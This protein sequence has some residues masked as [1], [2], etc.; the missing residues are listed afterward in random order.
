MNDF[1]VLDCINKNIFDN[2]INI[3]TKILPSGK[4]H[5]RLSVYNSYIWKEAVENFKL[6]NNK[7]AVIE[8]PDLEEKY[9][10]HFVR[11]LV[12]T[13]GCFS[14]SRGRLS[15]SYG[16]CSGKFIE[17]LYDVFIKYCGINKIKISRTEK[18][19]PYHDFY[20]FKLCN[21]KDP[22]AI[23]QWIY[24]NSENNRGER[25]FNIWLKSYINSEFYKK[26]LT[27]SNELKL[28]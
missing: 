19:L 20:V 6:C 12:D 28:I 11:G 18:Q 25:K 24:N 17:K 15:F 23:G 1:D 5:Y 8:F 7:S 21:K 26:Q 9:L 4:T 10:P 14:T 2:K 3:K 13:D 27:M 16:S 22:I